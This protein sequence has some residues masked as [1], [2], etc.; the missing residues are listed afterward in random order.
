MKVAAPNR[1][2]YEYVQTLAAP[3]EELFP[4]L[5]PVREC[6]WVNGWDPRVVLTE[7]GVA[8]LDCVFI[9]P[10]TPEEAVWVVTRYEPELFRLEWLK[11]IPGMVVA[12]IIIKL[13]SIPEGT[14]AAI[15]YCY[16]SLSPQGDLAI[17]G[18]SQEHFDAFMRAWEQELNHYLLVGEKLPRKKPS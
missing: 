16:T 17:E 6:D 13:E 15:S 18:L 4:L 2:T 11:L 10:A 7:S 9:T 8:E 5:C 12:K 14:S 1:I 3:P